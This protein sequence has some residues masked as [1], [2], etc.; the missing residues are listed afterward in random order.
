MRY[1]ANELRAVRV[2]RMAETVAI[3]LAVVVTALSAVAAKRWGAPGPALVA[4]DQSPARVIPVSGPAPGDETILPAAADFIAA[5]AAPARRE[6]AQGVI[7]TP[8]AGYERYFDGRPLMRSRTIW[9]TVTAYSPDHRSCGEYADGKTA[10]MKSV[11]TNGMRLVAADPKVLKMGSLIT[12]PGYGGGEVV[13]VLDVGGAIKGARLD[14]LFPSHAQARKW[15]VRKLKVTVW[16]YA[17]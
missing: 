1:E 12:V 9:M 8:P 5:I 3:V 11:W 15:G 13:P 7:I 2:R 4:I 14:V 6:A 16:E 10:T 17:D